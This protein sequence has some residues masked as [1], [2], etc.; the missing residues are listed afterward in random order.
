MCATPKL[1]HTHHERKKCVKRV[2][3]HK[4]PHGGTAAMWMAVTTSYK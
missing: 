1:R 2:E 4:V 3:V